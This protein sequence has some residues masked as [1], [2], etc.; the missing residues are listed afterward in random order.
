MIMVDLGEQL[1]KAIRRSGL[2]RKQISDQ[3]S[4]GYAAIHGFMA[5]TRDLTLTSASKIADV[6]GVELKP[7]RRK[8]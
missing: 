1:K 5:G 8:A 7:R 2:T 6:V 4:V 3:A